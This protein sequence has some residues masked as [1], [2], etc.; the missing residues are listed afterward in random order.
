MEPR[1][2][3]TMRELEAQQ[4]LEARIE[5]PMT[6]AEAIDNLGSD[7]FWAIIIAAVIRGFL[8]K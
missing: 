3:P 8:N 5:T 6:T 4:K 7:L 1:K 2:F